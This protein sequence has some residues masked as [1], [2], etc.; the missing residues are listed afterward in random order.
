MEMKQFDQLYS[1]PKEPSLKHP[2]DKPLRIG[3]SQYRCHRFWRR[4]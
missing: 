1:H 2:G 4:V 3:Y